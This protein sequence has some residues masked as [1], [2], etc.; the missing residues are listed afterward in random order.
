[1]PP[2]ARELEQIKP[3][4]MNVIS[5]ESGII[6]P[7]N[8]L[9]VAA[10]SAEFFEQIKGGGFRSFCWSQA[11][12]SE[13]VVVVR[14]GNPYPAPWITSDIFVPQH[15]FGTRRGHQCEV[16]RPSVLPQTR[17]H[18]SQ[19]RVSRKQQASTVVPSSA[20]TSSESPIALL[21]LPEQV[22]WAFEVLF[23]DGPLSKEDA[24]RRLVDAFVL[25]GLA[26]EGSAK[27]GSPERQLMDVILE[28]GVVQGRFDKPK[29]GQFRAIRPDPRDYSSDDW[30]M[31][32]TSA[33][34]QS[35]TEREAALR[36]AAYW[37]ASNTGLAFSRLQRG[38]AILGGLDA[39]LELAL[40]R[41]RFVDDGNGCV[42]KV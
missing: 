32:L 39:A 40:Q 36:F 10:R 25:L 23:G 29:R 34:D 4:T 38:G 20:E 9:V 35:P 12:C 37:A 24:V 1:L 11:Y 3:S 13:A 28:A 31:C 33:L 16:H 41:G 26:N 2:L 21:S 14:L 19:M 8:L 18:E 30:I 5:P 7:S 27:R 17:H 42:Q 15:L 6:T 22:A